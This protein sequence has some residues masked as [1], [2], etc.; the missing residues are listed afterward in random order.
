MYPGT[1][2]KRV[3]KLDPPVIFWVKSDLTWNRMKLPLNILSTAILAFISLDAMSAEK[4]KPDEKTSVAKT[5]IRK[6]PSNIMTPWLSWRTAKK[7]QQKPGRVLT[8][9]GSTRISWNSGGITPWLKEL[10]NTIL[11][12][13]GKKPHQKLS[14][15]RRAGMPTVNPNF[16][17][18]EKFTKNICILEQWKNAWQSW[19]RLLYFE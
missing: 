18:T 12:K 17:E 1:M 14:R 3:T 5:G 7:P 13:P 10:R 15:H 11:L 4:L 8:W 2:K 16:S 19:I 6:Y 9:T